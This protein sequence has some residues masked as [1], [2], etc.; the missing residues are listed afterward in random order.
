ML[1]PELLLKHAA[2]ALI[3]IEQEVKR[4][5]MGFCSLWKDAAKQN[6]RGPVGSLLLRRGTSTCRDFNKECH[7]QRP[8]R[9]R[10]LGLP[11]QWDISLIWKKCHQQLMVCARW[12]NDPQL[13]APYPSIFL[14]RSQAAACSLGL[15]EVNIQS[16][17]SFYVSGRKEEREQWQMS[18]ADS[19][20][21]VGIRIFLQNLS[22]IN[23]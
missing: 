16:S 8:H 12:D 4:S 21:H 18:S 14:L 13:G 5:E 3:C 1:N 22:T 9:A 10:R 6:I 19:G 17:S 11:T 23:L 15:W 2:C 20:I 7:H